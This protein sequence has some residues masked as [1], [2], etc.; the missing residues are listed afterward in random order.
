M[1]F[2]GPTGVAVVY[3]SVFIDMFGGLMAVPVMPFIIKENLGCLGAKDTSDASARD[4]FPPPS[5]AACIPSAEEDGIETRDVGPEEDSCGDDAPRILAAASALYQFASIFSTPAM[6]KLSDKYGRRPFFMVGFLG[7]CLGFFVIGFSGSNTGLLAG[8]FIGGLFSASPPLAQAYISDAF[9]PDKSPL[10]RARLGSAALI[11]GPGFG[12]GLSQFGNAFPFYVA[13]GLA[14][15]GFLLGLFYLDEPPR[16]EKKTDDKGPADGGRATSE[17]AQAKAPII[18]WLFAAGFLVNFGFRVFMMMFGLWLFDKARAPDP[19]IGA[20]QLWRQFGWG[21]G[22][23]GFI[24]SVT[25]SIGIFANLALFA[26]L[27]QKYGK[28]QVAI[29]GAT[30]ASAGWAICLLSRTSG[31]CDGRFT[32]DGGMVFIMGMSI[33]HAIGFTFY[34]TGYT[35][36]LSLYAD[37]N[38]QGAAIAGFM[39]PIV[40]AWLYTQW[41]W[42]LLPIFPSCGELALPGAAVDEPAGAALAEPEEDEKTASQKGLAPLPLTASE[43]EELETL[44]KRVQELERVLGGVA[45]DLMLSP[46][47]IQALDLSQCRHSRRVAQDPRLTL[48]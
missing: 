12:G 10:Y 2:H 32:L 30:M 1:K 28:H 6:T 40:G 41:K 23:F 47:Q 36:L 3:L 11:F 24:T 5:P 14:M 19:T 8:R 45:D 38:S 34:N 31:P 25:G 43:R 44:R 7:S 22:E 26:K 42:E 20:A 39:G 13:S 35:T 9:P 33:G 29:L 21:A 16:S 46:E 15:C 4:L 37:K 27:A 17:L 48:H 18:R